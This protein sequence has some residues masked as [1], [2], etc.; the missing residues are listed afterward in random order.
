MGVIDTTDGV[1]SNP[2]E[3]DEKECRK[4][5]EREAENTEGGREGGERRGSI[6]MGP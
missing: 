2:K 3:R 6:S 1:L 5:R 4:G